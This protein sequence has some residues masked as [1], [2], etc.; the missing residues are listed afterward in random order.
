MSRIHDTIVDEETEQNY[1]PGTEILDSG[2]RKEFSSGAVR[3]LEEGK[4]S[5]DLLPCRTLSML[6]HFGKNYMPC[7]TQ[8]KKMSSVNLANVVMEMLSEFGMSSDINVWVKATF[9]ALSLF[10]EHGSEDMDFAGEIIPK[11][12]NYANKKIPRY[13][14]IPYEGL[15]RVAE[16][17]RKGALKYSS[18]NWEKGMHLSRFRSSAMRHLMQFIH[19]MEDEPHLD[20]AVWN[21]MC[22][23]ETYS[24]IQDG[25]LS[26][27]FIGDE[28]VLQYMLP[29]STEI[30]TP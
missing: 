9:L 8:I 16:H 13:D 3:D 23:L 5:F 21:M 25:S 24:R 14:N 29:K 26:T 17:F 18:R 28:L 2:K 27:E 1:V 7:K 6:A 4:G 22:Y 15:R 10:E 20:A 11:N 12:P 19:G 30:L